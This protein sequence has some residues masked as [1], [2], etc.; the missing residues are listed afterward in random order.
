VELPP[1]NG[2]YCIG[3]AR[4]L[5]R[6]QRRAVVLG[7]ERRV[8]W[9]DHAGAPHL[10][11]AAC[12]HLGADLAALATVEAD[13]LRCPFHGFGFD[14]DGRCVRTGYGTA[15]PNGARLVAAPLL[16]Q[17]GLLLAWH[18]AVEPTWQPP[19]LGLGREPWSWPELRVLRIAGHPQD[20]SE[21]SV[22]TGHFGWVHGYSDLEST[23]PLYTQGAYLRAAYRFRRRLPGLSVGP[24]ILQDIEVHLHGLGYSVVE[25]HQ[26]DTNLLFRLLVLATPTEPGRLELTLGVATGPAH[27]SA[28]AWVRRLAPLL[29]PL[30]RPLFA[31][32]YRGEVND[33]VRFWAQKHFHPRPAL[34]AGDGPIGP[35]RAWC[36]QFYPNPPPYQMA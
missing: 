23:A 32:I 33:D 21:N 31:A 11:A 15:P 14:G 2:W 12:P 8:L 4:E 19:A 29:A 17:D 3:A 22:D 1:P 35:Y 13:G 16:E 18:G 26:T 34:A 10:H 28:G 5:G 20:T 6:G 24:R 27:G 25:L 36:R 30:I 9:R 7:G